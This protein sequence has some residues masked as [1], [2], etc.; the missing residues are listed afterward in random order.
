[1]IYFQVFQDRKQIPGV[2]NTT[3]NF[4]PVQ[5]QWSN[6]I[7]TY[8]ILR[9]AQIQVLKKIIYTTQMRKRIFKD[10]RV[11]C[12]HS[13]QGSITLQDKNIIMDLDGIY[14]CLS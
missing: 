14:V 6:S 12:T 7:N 8:L 4:I 5:D 10:K 11:P 13:E 3:W 1:M 9:D 2:F